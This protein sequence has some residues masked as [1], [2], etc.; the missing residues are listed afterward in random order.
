MRIDIEAL[1]QFLRDVKDGTIKDIET[2]DLDGDGWVITDNGYYALLD[3]EEVD[4]E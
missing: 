1:K 3:D 4:E 2:I